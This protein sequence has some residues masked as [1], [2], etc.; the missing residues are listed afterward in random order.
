MEESVV[1][2]SRTWDVPDEF[3]AMWWRSREYRQM[4]IDVTVEPATNTAGKRLAPEFQRLV[5]DQMEH[6]GR[7][8]M[9]GPVALD[10]HFRAAQRNPPS[11][12][13]SG[14][15]HPRRGPTALP[16]SQESVAYSRV[17]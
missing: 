11:Y 5:M 12:L 9:R 3:W 13:P 14:Q 10:L 1:G 6:Y 7:Y 2:L 16:G 4:I 8:P 15:V 17:G